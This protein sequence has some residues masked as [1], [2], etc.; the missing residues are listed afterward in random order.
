MTHH[1]DTVVTMVN[2]VNV[3]VL[4]AFCVKTIIP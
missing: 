1:G 4:K 2:I 3:N